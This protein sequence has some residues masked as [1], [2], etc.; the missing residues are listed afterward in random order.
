MVFPHM[1]SLLELL[2]TLNTLSPLAVI[3]LLGVVIYKLVGGNKSLTSLSEDSSSRLNEIATN[4]L[5]EL[6]DMAETLRRIEK[7]QTESFT[8][9]ITLLENKR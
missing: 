6:P 8:K 5:H 9:M 3:A 4:H 1:D 7:Q 2:K